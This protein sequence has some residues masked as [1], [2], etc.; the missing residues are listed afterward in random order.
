MMYGAGAPK[1]PAFTPYAPG[2]LGAPTTSLLLA[3]AVDSWD[4]LRQASGSH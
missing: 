4:K 1:P 2:F 3:A